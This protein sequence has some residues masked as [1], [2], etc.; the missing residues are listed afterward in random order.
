MRK[1]IFIGTFIVSAF[2]FA[3]VTNAAVQITSNDPNAQKEAFPAV[4]S[5]SE[6]STSDTTEKP[7]PVP[8]L[9]LNKNTGSLA[10]PNKAEALDFGTTLSTITTMYQMW[11]G[12]GSLNDTDQPNFASDMTSLII[13]QP[14]LTALMSGDCNT[15]DKMNKATKLKDLEN[16]DPNAT[17]N[18]DEDPTIGACVFTVGTKMFKK[19]VSNNEGKLRNAGLLGYTAVTS[20]NISTDPQVPGNLAFF[21]NDV[22]SNSMI[23]KSAYA[24]SMGLN[25]AKPDNLFKMSVYV[26]WKTMRNIAMTLVAVFL[27]VGAIGVIFRQ[28]MPGGAVITIYSILPYVPVVIFLI[29]FSYPILVIAMNFGL[30]LNSMGVLLART[31]GWSIFSEGNSNAVGSPYFFLEAWDNWW[32]TALLAILNAIPGI[33]FGLLVVIFLL[34]LVLIM[35]WTFLYQYAKVYMRFVYYTIF[36]PIVF[37]SALAPGKQGNITNFFKLVLVEMLILPYAIIVYWIAIG[38]LYIGVTGQLA[39]SIFLNPPGFGFLSNILIII[40]M[41]M[42]SWHFVW[43]VATARNKVEEFL[44]VKGNDIWGPKQQRR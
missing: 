27:A 13:T 11:R 35:F 4:K 2:V 44:G 16:Q 33:F 17:P 22:V 34:I 25:L 43:S 41:F 37:L 20:K 9:N 15:L 8:S 31:I 10:K 14:V 30:G 7:I 42:I 3:T 26:L 19:Y 24:Q 39:D 28:K 29:L 23:G 1:K 36:A 32:G 40:V 38:F 12:L 6:T 21:T 5:S 18:P